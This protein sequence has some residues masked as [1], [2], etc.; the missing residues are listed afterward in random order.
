MGCLILGRSL[1]NDIAKLFSSKIAAQVLVFLTAP[2]IARIFTPENIGI[3][4]IVLSIA[5]VISVVTCLRY[6]LSIPVAK[7]QREASAGFILSLFFTFIFTSLASVVVF[8]GGDDI[9]RKYYTPEVG[10]FLWLLP[11]AILLGGFNSALIAWTS[12][13]R[14]FG[15]LAWSTFTYAHAGKPVSIFLG[16]FISATTASLFFGYFS[17]AVLGVLMFTA[18]MG[19]GLIT[20]IRES[21]LNLSQ[22]YS[23][24]RD[25][26]KFPLYTTWQGLI[27]ALSNELPSMLLGIFFTTTIVGYYSQGYALVSLPM[28][29]LGVS[30]SQIFYPTAAK[31]YNETGSLKNIVTSMYRVLIQVGIFPILVMAFCGSVLFSL[32]LGEK[33]LEAGIYAQILSGYVLFQFMSSPLS[34]TFNILQR[35]GTALVINIV[36][37]ILKAMALFSG[38]Y[39]GGPRLTLALYT[40]VSA[41]GYGYKFCWVFQNTDVSLKWGAGIFLKYILL[42]SALLAPVSFLVYRWQNIVFVLCILV[43]SLIIYLYILYRFEATFRNFVK[44]TVFKRFDINK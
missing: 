8:L 18:F 36:I 10:K 9:A 24:A 17:G 15:V 43:I 29:M 38:S 33:W 37:L 12:R 20:D 44:N 31:E 25:Y 27:N 3:R 2:A 16:I 23:I 11:L 28:A 19:R 14:K 32:V 5:N 22:I 35:Q 1:G 26:W 40:V 30:F 34:T 41:F 4:R 42:S 7:D 13:E 39:L 6:D 21:K